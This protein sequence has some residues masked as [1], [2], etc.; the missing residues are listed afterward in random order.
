MFNGS[1]TYMRVY[2]DGEL[3]S[4]TGASFTIFNPT[5]D[6]DVY[7][8][9]TFVVTSENCGSATAVTRFLQEG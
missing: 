3:T 1:D 6:G 9:Y 4:H 7:G 8:T 5:D 2:K